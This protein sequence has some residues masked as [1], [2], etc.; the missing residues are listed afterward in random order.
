M[1]LFTLLHAP[2]NPNLFTLCSLCALPVGQTLGRRPSVVPDIEAWL[3]KKA[4]ANAKAKA[5]AEAAARAEAQRA[6]K[7]EAKVEAKRQREAEAAARQEEKRAR[8]DE[9]ANEQ[10]AKAEARAEAAAHRANER[11]AGAVAKQAAAE[12]KAQARSKSGCITATSSTVLKIDLS[13]LAAAAAAPRAYGK[14]RVRLH[15]AGVVK[16]TGRVT[17][18]HIKLSGV[19]TSHGRC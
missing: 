10:R 5:K 17:A 8:Q 14:I 3:R 19:Y 13:K 7:V 6:A 11:L 16:R 4:K 2:T 12:A 18:V 15:G 1:V 9:R